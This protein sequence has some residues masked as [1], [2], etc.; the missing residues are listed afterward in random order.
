M[1]YHPSLDY[2]LEITKWPRISRAAEELHIT[3]QSL[4]IY[5]KRLEN[6]YGTTLFE[7]TPSLRLTRDGEILKEAAEQIQNIYRS[8][9]QEIREKNRPGL[10]LLGCIRCNTSELLEAL[11]FVEYRKQYPNVHIEIIDEHSPILE[12]KLHR[13]ELHFYLGISGFGSEKTESV[14]F[15][16][17]P[18]Y[19]LAT[20]TLLQ[21]YFGE[22]TEALIQRWQQGI[23]L[24]E[25]R[26]L[27][28][29]LFPEH[30]RISQLAAAYAKDNGYEMKII[31]ESF[32]QELNLTL[33]QSDEGY[34]I[35][36]EIPDEKEQILAFP[37][38]T[39]PITRRIYCVRERNV[40]F[41]S[42]AEAFWNLMLQT[43]RT[44]SRKR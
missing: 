9:D 2:F 12:R 38:Q 34:T 20:A 4:S 15:C 22:E 35:S 28:V 31:F 24:K 39:P 37:L 8:L 25:I 21:K 27:P 43:G 44:L 6:F 13:K 3:Q 41:P 16:E 40:A 17:I 32:S 19:V 1:A 14:P 29:V 23:C 30:S 26:Q 5:L 42:Y 18:L 33:V 10:I 36:S 11:P 7:R